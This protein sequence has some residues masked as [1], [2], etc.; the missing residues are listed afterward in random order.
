M[1]SFPLRN[2]FT[3]QQTERVRGEVGGKMKE[4]ILL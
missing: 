4:G 1:A 3:V 2:A